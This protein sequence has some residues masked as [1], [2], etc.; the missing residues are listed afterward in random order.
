LPEDACIQ[1]TRWRLC[2]RYT[3]DEIG[4][5]MKK[6]LATALLALTLG[7]TT[8]SAGSMAPVPT[9]PVIQSPPPAPVA[10]ARN[11]TGGYGGVQLGY[12]QARL[13]MTDTGDATNTGDLRANGL[14][15]GVYGGFNWQ[16]ANDMVFGMDADLAA[17]RARA[18]TTTT[19][20][21]AIGTRLRSSGAVRARAGVAMGD[22]LFYG[23][24]GVAHGRFNVDVNGMGDSI[25]RTGW[26]AGV[27]I[28]QAFAGSMTGRLEYR[29]TDYGSL[30]T[31]GFNGRL[32]S[33]EVR[34]GV[35]FNF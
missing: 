24:A 25:G 4:R 32:R 21:D 12:G 10:M 2:C 35:A 23:A 7:T 26:T 27:G 34:A 31:N 20:G 8:A 30:T 9:E 22:T 18:D 5:T 6:T 11:W 33:N 1:T 29:H 14:L 28:E 13:G 16:G 19:G 15:G 17:N 3:H